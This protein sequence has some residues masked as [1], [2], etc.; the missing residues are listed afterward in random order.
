MKDFKLSDIESQLN[1]IN[2][3]IKNGRMEDASSHI[4]SF[5][6]NEL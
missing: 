2:T 4:S 6:L 1:H 3:L 5:I